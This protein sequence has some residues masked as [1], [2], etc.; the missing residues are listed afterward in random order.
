MFTFSGFAMFHQGRCWAHRAAS[1]AWSK[2]CDRMVQWR[3][4]AACAVGEAEKYTQPCSTS[5]DVSWK[6]HRFVSTRMSGAGFRDI[7]GFPRMPKKG[8]TKVEPW[9]SHCIKAAAGGPCRPALRPWC[10]GGWPQ[11]RRQIQKRECQEWTVLRCV[12]TSILKSMKLRHRLCR[13]LGPTC[14]A[15]QWQLGVATAGFAHSFPGAHL[16]VC[17]VVFLKILRISLPIL[18]C[19]G[20]LPRC[21]WSTC[22]GWFALGFPG[23]TEHRCWWTQKGDVLMLET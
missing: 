20:R 14:D 2:A 22:L 9:A 5:F 16:N 1:A 8:V 13:L 12:K 21:W 11:G 3:G 6:F 18:L 10:T 4:A 15:H 7:T 19:K 17:P 23:S